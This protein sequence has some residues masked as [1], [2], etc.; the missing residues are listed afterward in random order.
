VQVCPVTPFPCNTKRQ[1]ATRWIA[2]RSTDRERGGLLCGKMDVE[3]LLHAF[4]DAVL[5]EPV[6]ARLRDLLPR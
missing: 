1:I 3:D 4:Y 2:R 6:P 5:D